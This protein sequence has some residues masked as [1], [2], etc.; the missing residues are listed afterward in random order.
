MYVYYSFTLVYSLLPTL[1]KKTLKCRWILVTL[2]SFDLGDTTRRKAGYFFKVPVGTRYDMSPEK[3]M[4]FLLQVSNRCTIRNFTESNEF[5]HLIYQMY[6]N[7]FE[8]L[9]VYPILPILNSKSKQQ[10]GSSILI[11]NVFHIL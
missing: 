4:K 8:Q 2:T 11:F 1:P 6:F 9:L 10:L 3:A 5:K 7:L